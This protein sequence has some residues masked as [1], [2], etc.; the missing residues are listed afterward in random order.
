ML[1]PTANSLRCLLWQLGLVVPAY[2]D[3]PEHNIAV[4]EAYASFLPVKSAADVSELLSATL[5]DGSPV[6]D[7]F[8]EDYVFRAAIVN[9]SAAR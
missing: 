2:T 1:S 6:A 3:D 9:D 4:S 5:E 7:S 8:T